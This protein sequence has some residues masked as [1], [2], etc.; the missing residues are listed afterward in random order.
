MSKA[1][2]EVKEKIASLVSQRNRIDK[3]PLTAKERVKL[4]DQIYDSSL[5]YLLQCVSAGTMKGTS[6]LCQILERARLEAY[7]LRRTANI[8]TVEKETLGWEYP[9][10]NGDEIADA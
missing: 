4:L 1:Y 3:D 8:F 10:P 6:A 7:D 2:D 5:I 9:D